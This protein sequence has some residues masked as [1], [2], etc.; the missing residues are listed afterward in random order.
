MTALPTFIKAMK[1]K[2]LFPK[3][4]Q[5]S[6]WREWT[7]VSCF[8]KT[9][10]SFISESVAMGI[11]KNPETALFKGLTEYLERRLA[12]ASQDPIVGLTERTDGFAAF[13]IELFFLEWDEL[14]EFGSSVVD[15]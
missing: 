2:D 6:E 8:D 9:N 1:S 10:S 13:P 14:R 15:V 5:I 4:V 7:L 3:N 12:K 11:D